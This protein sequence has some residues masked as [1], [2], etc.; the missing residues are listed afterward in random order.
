[1]Q[2][3]G[4]GW[5]LTALGRQKLLVCYMLEKPVKVSDGQWQETPKHQRTILQHYQEL[6]A[7]GWTIAVQR[8]R[9]NPPVAHTAD[10]EQKVACVCAG[11]LCR[12][13]FAALA[14]APTLFELGWLQIPHGE[15]V[16]FYRSLFDGDGHPQSPEASRA[17]SAHQRKEAISVMRLDI[18]VTG[19]DGHSV[20]VLQPRGKHQRV[21]P[22]HHHH[23]EALRI[24]ELGE[25]RGGEAPEDAMA[26]ARLAGNLLAGDD[27]DPL[28]GDVLIHGQEE[29][30]DD[31]D[32]L[33]EASR[34]N[35]RS[36]HLSHLKWC[37]PRAGSLTPSPPPPP[38]KNHRTSCHAKSFC[39]PREDLL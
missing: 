22:V 17:S 28:P 29:D 25:G 1:M 7:T 3:T 32:V 20:Q 8:T 9:R 30:A 6:M 4:L 10:S 2:Q 11:V 39:T 38:H 19:P 15:T 34:P 35:H 23:E 13:Y 14:Y 26:D 33:L 5:S 18:E 37:P 24:P 27:D 31:S 21:D 12:H 16:S 36:H